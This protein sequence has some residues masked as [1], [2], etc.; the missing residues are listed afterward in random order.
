M[1]VRD[2]VWEKFLK[3]DLKREKGAV[4]YVR[5][6]ENNADGRRQTKVNLL[7]QAATEQDAGSPACLFKGRMIVSEPAVA[8]AAVKRLI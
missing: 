7:C 3:L 5:E 2:C 4:M 6:T 1:C 8:V